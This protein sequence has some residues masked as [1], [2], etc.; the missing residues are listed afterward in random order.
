MKKR[1]CIGYL[2]FSF[3]VGLAAISPSAQTGGRL[4]AAVPFDFN[5][6]SRLLPAGEY[7]IRQ[8][9]SGNESLSMLSDGKQGA[10]AF[11]RIVEANRQTRR[12][13]LVF[14]RYG[15]RYFLASIR[16]SR[17]EGRIL[18]QSAD[19]RS[20]RSETASIKKATPEIVVVEL[21]SR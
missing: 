14:N 7:T 5:V 1:A 21:A 13:R 12:S 10:L 16:D 9:G 2:F 11:A 3:L 19:E 8:P 18:P 6:G 15:E 4:A 17:G 20:V